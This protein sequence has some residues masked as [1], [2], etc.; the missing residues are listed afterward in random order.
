M[1]ISL[2]ESIS[3]LQGPSTGHQLRHIGSFYIMFATKIAALVL[4]TMATLAASQDPCCFSTG[5]FPFRQGK[6]VDK[7]SIGSDAVAGGWSTDAQMTT[8]EYC[9][10]KCEGVAGCDVFVFT[11]YV[12]RSGK[13]LYRCAMWK[14]DAWKEIPWKKWMN[15]PGQKATWGPK[16]GCLTPGGLG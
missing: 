8:P 12:S 5:P 14:G 15:M 6:E 9:Q 1:G 11:D 16:T 3:R 2:P 10:K 4:V 7:S 13:Q